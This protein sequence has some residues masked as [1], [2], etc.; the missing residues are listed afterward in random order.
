MHRDGNPHHSRKGHD[1][2]RCF[3]FVGLGSLLVCRLR[4]VVESH[5]PVEMAASLDHF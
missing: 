1:L 2:S 3:E 5:T 4:F